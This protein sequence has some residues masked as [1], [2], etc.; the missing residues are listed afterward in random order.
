VKKKKD[1]QVSL[2]E[3]CNILEVDKCVQRGETT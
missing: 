1:K 3:K 2:E